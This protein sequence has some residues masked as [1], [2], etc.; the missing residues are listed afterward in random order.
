MDMIEWLSTKLTISRIKWCLVNK[1]Y[2]Q[3]NHIF[4]WQIYAVICKLDF[5]VFSAINCSFNICLPLI[6]GYTLYL[7]DIELSRLV[8]YY[9]VDCMCPG[10]YNTHIIQLAFQIHGFSICEYGGPA[11][12]DLT[13]CEL[14]VWSPRSNSHGYWEMSVFSLTLKP[15]WVLSTLA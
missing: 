1:G 13:I 3:I 4:Q 15:G 7:S 11:V 9:E 8:E 14:R 6:N 12:R 10:M 5:T 2:F